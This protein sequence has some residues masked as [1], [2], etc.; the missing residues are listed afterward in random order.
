LPRGISD[1]QRALP[2]GFRDSLGISG[3]EA[4][5]LRDDAKPG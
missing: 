3:T 1:K 4:A 5:G 2:A